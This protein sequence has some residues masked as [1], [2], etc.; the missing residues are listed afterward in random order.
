MS[1]AS[2]RRKRELR[3]SGKPRSGDFANGACELLTANGAG[4]LPTDFDENCRL[5]S[6]RRWASIRKNERRIGI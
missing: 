3:S 4:E 6:L 2:Y 5:T 1:I